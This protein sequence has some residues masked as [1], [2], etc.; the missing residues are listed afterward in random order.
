MKNLQRIR[1]ER[2]LSQSALADLSGVNRT[3]IQHY[4]IG[5]RDINKASVVNVYK[6]SKVLE[7]KIEDLMQKEDI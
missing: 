7:C 5:I 6:L 3:S 2:G 4:E 1:K